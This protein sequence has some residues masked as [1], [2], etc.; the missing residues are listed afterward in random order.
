MPIK[1]IKPRKN[2]QE[3]SR[4]EFMPVICTA[5]KENGHYCNSHLGDIE[6]TRPNVSKH[7]CRTCKITYRHEVSDDGTVEVMAFTGAEYSTRPTVRAMAA[8]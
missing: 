1:V 5:M 2:F 3:D 4:R 6:T 8:S 7:R